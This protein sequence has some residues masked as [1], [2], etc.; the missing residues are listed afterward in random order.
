[1]HWQTWPALRSG[2]WIILDRWT[3]APFLGP[4]SLE[5]GSASGVW[6]PGNSFACYSHSARPP[7]WPETCV[8]LLG[9][10]ASH[11]KYPQ[12]CLQVTTGSRCE[13]TYHLSD[14]EGRKRAACERGGGEENKEK[15]NHFRKVKLFR[16]KHNKLIISKH[17]VVLSLLTPLVTRVTWRGEEELSCWSLCIFRPVLQ[18]QITGLFVRK[19][20]TYD[21]TGFLIPLTEMMTITW[22]CYSL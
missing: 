20:T 5:L 22:N 13:E 4:G 10:G 11:S 3:Y 15:K 6:F 18:A 19:N 21:P 9:G 2:R 8:G 12:G 17:S 1:M 14:A 7:P 16:E